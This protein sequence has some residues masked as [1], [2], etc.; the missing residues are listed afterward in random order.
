VDT[1]AT[2]SRTGW[3]TRRSRGAWRGSL[4]VV[5]FVLGFAP[6][7]PR[8]PSVGFDASWVT[9][10]REA[11]SGDIAWGTDFVYT[12][13]PLGDLYTGAWSPESSW[14]IPV[15]GII[16]CTIVAALVNELLRP[17]PWWTT[18][19]AALLI[20]SGIFARDT[21][22]L[23]PPYVLAML[24]LSDRPRAES[25]APTRRL[26]WLALAAV[27]AGLLPLVKLSGTPIA[28]L[29]IGFCVLV[30]ARRRDWSRAVVVLIVPGASLVVAWLLVGQPVGSLWEWARTSGMVV[31][32]YSQALAQPGPFVY[33]VIFVAC[34]ALVTLGVMARLEPSPGRLDRVAFAGLTAATCFLAFKA[35]FVRQD[36]HV[37]IAASSL[38]A[39][40]VIAACRLPRLTAAAVSAVGVL[41][42]VAMAHA[43]SASAP[44]IVSDGLRHAWLEAPQSAVDRVF[45]TGRL[46]ARYQAA[47]DAVRRDP[48][49]PQVST[50]GTYDLYTSELSFLF[51][52]G[53]DWSPRPAVQ[54][55]TAYT[56]GLAERDRQHSESGE[57]PDHLLVR[58][59]LRDGVWAQMG[60]GASWLSMARWYD[61]GDEAGQYV[62]L[63][64]RQEPRAVEYGSMR[65]EAVQLGRDL[66]LET[67]PGWDGLVASIQL[68]SSWRGRL[69]STLLRSSPVE[70]T[71]RLDDGSRFTRR[72][73]PQLGSVEVV[74][75]PHVNSAAALAS[76]IDPNSPSREQRE[77][78]SIR[79]R[80]DTPADWEQTVTIAYRPFRIV[81]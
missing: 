37:L 51:A 3:L 67:P 5:A 22:Y 81:S 63:D 20:T 56:P 61:Y 14:L 38:L 26:W 68:D 29:S 33:V 19:L 62:R 21:I 35:G 50:G 77:A 30:L 54:S 17:H 58:F 66:T 47:E 27:P 71:E 9:A 8:Y 72:F 64:V 16:Y 41:A 44:G 23:L 45:R 53:V 2:P 15:I 73:L 75:S 60:D 79:F 69:V 1:S 32:G 49:M 65:T 34:A 4:L 46:E 55:R 39:V 43:A 36:G 59:D 40:A 78:E 42:W 12:I 70:I 7:V 80:A 10:V 25:L 28:V 31:S 52:Q 48:R 24:V 18:P 74:V 57:R 11:G 76:L 13:G 6:L